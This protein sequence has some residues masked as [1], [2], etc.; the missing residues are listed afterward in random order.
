MGGMPAIS[1][2]VFRRN[3]KKKRKW[4][5]VEKNI[6]RCLQSLKKYFDGIRDGL[7]SIYCI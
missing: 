3:T 5:N 2:R 4:D 1:E 7:D 6:I